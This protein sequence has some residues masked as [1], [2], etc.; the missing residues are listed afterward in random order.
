MR[1]DKEFDLGREGIDTPYERDYINYRPKVEYNPKKFDDYNDLSV[2]TA[3]Q[4]TLE[5]IVESSAINV[6]PD[7]VQ[8]VAKVNEIEETLSEKLKDVVVPVTPAFQEQ[9]KKAANALGYSG[10][11]DSIPFD[12]YKKTFENQSKPEASLIQDVFEDYMADVNGSLN[13]EVYADVAEL[14]NDWKDMQDFINKA[15]FS[16][17]VSLDK[18]PKDFTLDDAALEEIHEKEQELADEY[19]HQLKMK[20][21]N[22]ELYLQLAKANMNSDAYYKAVQE[23]DDSKREVLN[24]E[25]KLFTKSEIVDLVTGK[26]SDTNDNI[27]FISKTI[28]YEPFPD[29]K[30]ELIYNLIKQFGSKEEAVRG[31]RK[32]QAVLKLSI[33]GKKVT[34]D[35]M[36]SNLRGLAGRSAKQKINKTLINGVYLRNEVFTEVYDIIKHLD[37]VPNNSNFVAILNHISNGVEEAEQMYKSQASDFYKIHSMDSVVRTEKLIS[38]ID[39]DAARS[40]YQMIDRVVKYI[41]DVNQSWP[42]EEKLSSWLNDFMEYSKI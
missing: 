30:Y 37:G 19:A 42:N 35:S 15:L 20:S 12:L 5:E 14:Q 36:K 32:M 18:V 9:I 33:D 7:I 3:S 22:R 34:V 4:S 6:W 17:I 21:L 40:T 41:S 10:V 23:Y 8:T 26:A 24:L 28:D 16:Q 38:L 13:G 31:L 2:D 39:K 29:D 11:T 25:K 1:S 27:E